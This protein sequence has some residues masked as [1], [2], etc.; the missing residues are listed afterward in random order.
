[1]YE[2]LADHGLVGKTEKE[3]VWFI[4]RTMREAGADAASFDAIVGGGPNGA[5]PHHHPGNRRVE[6]NE[7]VVVDA[8]A[9]V[10]GYCS[11]CTRTFATGD[12]PGRARARLRGDEGRAAAGPRRDPRGRPGKRGARARPRA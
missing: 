2:A 12:L 4:E 9:V 3:L 6:P 8:G 5:V 1:M 11:D 7:L 10:D